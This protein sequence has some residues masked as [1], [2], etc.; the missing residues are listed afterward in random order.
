MNDCARPN[1]EDITEV[2][3]YTVDHSKKCAYWPKPSLS[4]KHLRVQASPRDHSTISPP[5]IRS[6][7]QTETL[8]VCERVAEKRVEKMK[9]K[10]DLSDVT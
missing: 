1:I 3:L 10:T 9:T 4:M 6:D 7:F 5:S 8:I 2:S